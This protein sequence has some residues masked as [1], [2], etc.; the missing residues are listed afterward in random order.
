MKLYQFPLGR[1]QLL[2][3]LSQDHPA[4]AC[5]KRKGQLIFINIE[6]VGFQNRLIGKSVR[7]VAP[8]LRHK[9]P[10]PRQA[11]RR[12]AAVQ[13]LDVRDRIQ[14]DVVLLNH[15]VNQ[16]GIQDA[17][18]H[19]DTAVAIIDAGILTARLHGRGVH[20]VE[21]IRVCFFDGASNPVLE[22]IV[23]MSR[24]R[25]ARNRIAKR[26]EECH[27]GIYGHTDAGHQQHGSV[28]GPF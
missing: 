12:D 24:P 15:R 11:L 25:T 8:G 26:R 5:G 7:P 1:I 23:R 17:V 3:V 27:P 16:R 6:A 9:V 20:P 10:Y 4:K 22:M 19:G 14:S 18:V 21:P 28:Y 13:I 2:I